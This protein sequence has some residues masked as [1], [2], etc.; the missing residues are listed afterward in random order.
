M[1]DPRYLINLKRII[2]NG[3][4]LWLLLAFSL[5]LQSCSDN[6]KDTGDYS[7][8]FKP[9]Y[10]TVVQ[11]YEIKKEPVVGVHYL[12]SSFKQLKHPFVNDSF[13]FFG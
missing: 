3:H 6:K 4:A 9:I 7:P 1:S 10:D 11:H 5:L 8:G 2:I 13:R 12:D